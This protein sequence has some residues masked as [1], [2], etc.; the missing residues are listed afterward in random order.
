MKRVAVRCLGSQAEQSA[1]QS[2]SSPLFEVT[3]WAVTRGAVTRCLTFAPSLS[4]RPFD[5]NLDLE[6]LAAS[7]NINTDVL[8]NTGSNPENLGESI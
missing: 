5:S 1:V 4:D 2:L 8:Q 6:I 7:L 3:R